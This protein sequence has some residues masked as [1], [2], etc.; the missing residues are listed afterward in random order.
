MVTEQVMTGKNLF[1]NDC[2]LKKVPN[3][4]SPSHH[5]TFPEVGAS[6][7]NKWFG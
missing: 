4:T 6:S 1:E 7:D 2:E 5:L 3:A